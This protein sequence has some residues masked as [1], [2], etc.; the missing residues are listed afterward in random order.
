MVNLNKKVQ[1][2]LQTSI[3]NNDLLDRSQPYIYQHEGS[4]VYIRGED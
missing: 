2:E 1:G 3:N 4:V